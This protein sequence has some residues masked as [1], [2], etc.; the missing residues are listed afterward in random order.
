MLRLLFISLLIISI[1]ACK[2]RTAE[3][4]PVH[5]QGKQVVEDPVIDAHQSLARI[6]ET[7]I[8]AYIKRYDWEMT[9]T[10]SGLRYMIYKEGYGVSPKTGDKVM[11][12]FQLSLIN[13][14]SCYSSDD[15]GP[16]VFRVGQADVERGLHEA[17][18]L[19]KVGDKAKLIVPSALG[20]G[21]IGD[22]N[23]IPKY[24]TL[25]YDIEL[26]GVINN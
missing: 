9:R 11:L 24:A 26:T 7:E 22:Q 25:I 21:L 19:M 23:C 1:S 16:K 17:V 18:L 14:T 6:E 10:E 20:F 5:D 3:R 2:D 15:D 4:L 12:D 8:E 13:G